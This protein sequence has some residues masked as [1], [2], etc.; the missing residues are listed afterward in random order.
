MRNKILLL[1][2]HVCCLVLMPSGFIVAQFDS[3]APSD[4]ISA[5]PEY[6]EPDQTISFA[7]DVYSID[8]S[9][10]AIR[11]FVDGI[12][13][14][15]AQN[16]RTIELVAPPLGTTQ[17]VRATITLPSGKTLSLDR[18]LK[19]SRVDILIEADTLTP[20]FYAGRALPSHGSNVRATAIVSGVDQ[21][22]LSYQWRV[23]GQPIYRGAIKGQR[24]ASFIAGTSNRSNIAVTVLDSSGAVIA[25]KL[26]EFPVVD[27]KIIFYS[28]NPLRGL[29]EVALSDPYLFIE[30]E[31]VLRAEPYYIDR[32]L[33]SGDYLHEWEINR[34][35]IASNNDDPL[36]ISLRN[37]GSG[38][39]TVGFHIR[40][41]G[42]LLQGSK[43]DITIRF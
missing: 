3:F 6:P 12:E 24:T 5:S 11:W 9:A 14:S 22:N 29:T 36:E 21:R 17:N 18:T 8:T 1:S 33:L 35:P 15:S 4:T 42:D 28:I 23:D 7:L 13:L 26:K 41:L 19:S 16:A 43:N 32:A 30:D 38:Q 34:N 25:K 37:Q 2:I 27:P 31:M 10:A 20:L 40:N 39:A